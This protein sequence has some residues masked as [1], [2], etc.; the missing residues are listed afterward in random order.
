MTVIAILQSR[1]QARILEV[2]LDHSHARG[3]SVDEPNTS[4]GYQSDCVLLIIV[5]HQKLVHRVEFWSTEDRLNRE[6]AISKT[7]RT[8]VNLI[9][10]RLGK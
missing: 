5:N 6:L 10:H 3:G 9:V 2:I 7:L 4:I 8:P 1:K